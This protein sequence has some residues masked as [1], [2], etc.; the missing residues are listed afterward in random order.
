[1]SSVEKSGLIVANLK[2]VRLGADAAK[3]WIASNES[4]DSVD[5]TMLTENFCSDG[6]ERSE[7][8]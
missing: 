1:M 2:S 8:D 6:S 3:E 7:S 4:M 5:E